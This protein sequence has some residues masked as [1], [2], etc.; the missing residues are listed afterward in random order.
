VGSCWLRRRTALLHASK[1]GHTE[2][3]K[4]LVFAGADV[5]ALWN[6]GL[7]GSGI[8]YVVPGSLATLPG[9]LYWHSDMAYIYMIVAGCL[10]ALQPNGAGCRVPE[11]QHGDGEG[12][13]SGGREHCQRARQGQPRVRSAAASWAKHLAFVLDGA[14]RARACCAGGRRCTM[15]QS[16]ALWSW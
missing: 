12:A 5:N 4:A 13:V 11:R 14:M 2:T 10:S 9:L 1:K 16:R 6:P 8:A 15:P 3:V 7:F